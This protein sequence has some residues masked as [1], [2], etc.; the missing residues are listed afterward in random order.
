MQT[1]L[2]HHALSCPNGG[3]VIT[4]HSEI[5]NEIIHLV[6]KAP[7]PNC[8]CGEPVIHL[9]RTRSEEEVHHRGRV[10]ETQCDVSTRGLWES[11]TEEIIDI[12][13]GDADT[14]TWVPEGVDKILAQWQKSRWTSMDI[15]AT[16]NRNI[17]LLLSSHLMG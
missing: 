11:Q 14:E 15:I 5:C 12:R 10:P 17:F 16:N 4:R 6:K 8:A 7:P 2:V 3:L 1:F 13:F 9:G